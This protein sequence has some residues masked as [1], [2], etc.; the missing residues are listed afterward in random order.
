MRVAHH[1]LATTVVF[2][3]ALSTAGCAT[4]PR[5]TVTPIP[6][7]TSTE[8]TQPELTQPST[9]FE[10]SCNEIGELV[11]FSTFDVP[12]AAQDPLSTAASAGQF[13]PPIAV[14]ILTDGGVRCEWAPGLPEY[15]SLAQDRAYPDSLL[16]VTVLPDT[17]RAV[18]EAGDSLRES[19]LS[20]CEYH[21]FFSYCS[22]EQAVGEYWVLIEMVGTSESSWSAISSAIVSRVA[23]LPASHASEQDPPHLDEQCA[24]VLDQEDV[25]TNYFAGKDIQPDQRS[26]HGYS[27]SVLTD[28]A[29]GYWTCRYYDSDADYTNSPVADPALARLAIEVLPSAGW[30]VKKLAENPAIPYLLTELDLPDAEADTAAFLRCSPITNAATGW[31]SCSIQ[32]AVGVDWISISANGGAKTEQA[33]TAV[34]TELVVRAQLP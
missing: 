7:V 25:A 15:L 34:A 2:G 14:S 20:D 29:L 5:A 28:A 17:T 9:R 19:S 23:Q 31:T 16:E 6:S 3:L 12:I 30:A 4:I 33:A 13:G 32:L 11:D 22:M 21:D 10:L 26:G 8:T 24:S 27:L 1:V 18:K